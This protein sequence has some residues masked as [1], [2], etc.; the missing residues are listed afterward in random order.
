MFLSQFPL[1]HNLICSLPSK[2]YFIRESQV[3]LRVLY[4]S[5]LCPSCHFTRVT[6]PL[7]VLSMTLRRLS[8]ALDSSSCISVFY[9]QFCF[10][11]FH[12]RVRNMLKSCCNFYPSIRELILLFFT[13]IENINRSMVFKMVKKMRIQDD[14]LHILNYIYI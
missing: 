11:G 2:K 6:H 8:T 10:N 3:H 14:Q 5:F 4:G 1:Y 13:I 7:T 9:L 12:V